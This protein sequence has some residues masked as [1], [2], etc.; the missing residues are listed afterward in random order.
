MSAYWTVKDAVLYLGASRSSVQRWADRFE[1]GYTGP[2]RER[3]FAASDIAA[4]AEISRLS[5]RNKSFEE[6]DD[7]IDFKQFTPITQFPRLEEDK[8]ITD[9]ELVQLEAR[10]R[11]IVEQYQQRTEKAEAELAASIKQMI[12]LEVTVEQLQGQLDDARRQSRDDVGNAQKEINDLRERI[13]R[14]KAIVEIYED[15]AKR[16]KERVEEMILTDLAS[17]KRGTK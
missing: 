3:R 12:R 2:R 5:D 8:E 17:K 13:G 16:A 15:D 14:M 11:A 1:L 7:E 9:S 10:S 6:M 4:L